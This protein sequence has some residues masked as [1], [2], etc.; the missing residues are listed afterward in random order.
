MVPKVYDLQNHYLQ[1]IFDISNIQN[2]KNLYIKKL[3]VEFNHLTFTYFRIWE[4]FN[5]L[6]DF[7]FILKTDDDSYIVIENLKHLLQPYNPQ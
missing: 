6:K 5:E 2:Q 3:L 1:L 7:D 4:E